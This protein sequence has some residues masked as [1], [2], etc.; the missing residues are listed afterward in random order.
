MPAGV[1]A[2]DEG[3]RQVSRGNSPNIKIFMSGFQQSR[4]TVFSRSN[5]NHQLDWIK[6]EAGQ[7]MM[8]W[9]GH[10]IVETDMDDDAS[11]TPLLS[12]TEADSADNN[13]STAS[14]YVVRFGENR[15]YVMGIQH[16]DG[17]EVEDKGAITNA[18]T[19]T[20][21]VEWLCGMAVFHPRAA[22]RVRHF[23]T[24]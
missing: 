19:E 2:L 3:V 14:I 23:Q 6:N 11:Q 20:T 4:L 15:D 18:T 7:Q 1:D 12:I 21:L 5:T 8:T 10:G 24:T 13:N 9:A 17:I 16:S 22:A